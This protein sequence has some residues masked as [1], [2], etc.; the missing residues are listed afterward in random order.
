MR[1][2]VPFLDAEVAELMIKAITDGD[3]MHLRPLYPW[4]YIHRPAIVPF[5]LPYALGEPGRQRDFARREIRE[6]VRWN[7]HAVLDEAARRHGDEAVR[8]VRVLHYPLHL[9]KFPVP[10]EELPPVLLRDREHV[11]PPTAMRHF[12]TLLFWSSP[13]HPVAG[14]DDVIQ[15]CDPGSL[16]EFA[17]TLYTAEFD[18]LTQVERRARGTWASDGV[19]YALERLGDDDTAARLATI[20]AR[21]STRL[22]RDTRAETVLD[23]FTAIG[24]DAA[25]RRLHRLTRDATDQRVIRP[26]AREAMH[27]ICERR[28]LDE[29]RLA[30]RLVPDFGLDGDGTKLLDYGPRSFRV[31]FDEQLRPYVVDGAGKRRAGLPK[32]GDK[33]D[34]GLAGAAREHFAEMRKETRVIA[35]DQI[36]R[37]ED[38]MINGRGWTVAE[39]RATYLDHPLLWHIARRLVWSVNGRP[40]RI[41]EDRTLADADDKPFTL[42]EEGTVTLPHPIHLGAEQA[43]WARLFADYEI[44]QP[45]AQLGRPVLHLTEE[46]RTAQRIVRFDGARVP[47]ERLLALPRRGWKWPGTGGGGRRWIIGR[48]V[49]PGQVVA[50]EFGPGIMLKDPA[51]YPEQT[52]TALEL[53]KELHRREE[54]VPFGDLPPAAASEILA[55]LSDL[56]AGTRGTP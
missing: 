18:S 28:G 47:N 8:A 1:G 34:A 19:R 51:A 49:A 6:F 16:A 14:L 13:R 37:L 39:F 10:V 17:W 21:W 29:Q 33:D 35:T 46:E 23:V 44:L 3:L 48:T 22:V 42:P 27:E 36:A 12:V 40:F 38:A 7:G 15:A 2:L 24:S 50:L 52:I 53:G 31:G 41:A 5:L 56:T 30:A 32:P 25:L 26:G 11:L 9:P 20:V 45:F 4:R 43:T 54:P 55:D